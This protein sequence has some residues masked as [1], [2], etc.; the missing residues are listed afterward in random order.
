MSEIKPCPFCGKPPVLWKSNPLG[1]FAIECE[2]HAKLGWFHFEEQAIESW[3]TRHGDSKAPATDRADRAI[4]GDA[5]ERHAKANLH[6]WLPTE[7][8][9][10]FTLLGVLAD[11]R[12]KTGLGD[13][14]MLS[15][16]ADTLAALIQNGDSAIDTNKRLTKRLLERESSW[17]TIDTVP[18]DGTEI[19]LLLIH[20]EKPYYEQR[21][22]GRW[23]HRFEHFLDWADE[24]ISL[25]GHTHFTHWMTIPDHWRRG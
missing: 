12:Q 11:I 10:E 23:S 1:N 22:V 16:L 5:V 14:V 21:I 18:K 25:K 9:D 20:P 4:D 8:P 13:K 19:L 6:E 15:D 2:G 7:Q 24:E 17:Q 3:N